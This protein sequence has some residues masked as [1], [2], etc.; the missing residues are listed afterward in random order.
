MKFKVPPNPNHSVVVH[1]HV[2]RI[3]QCDTFPL[4]FPFP[5]RTCL[6]LV[7]TQLVVGLKNW[8]K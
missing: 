8:N 5:G 6:V 7:K 3:Q 4:F 2:R 1:P